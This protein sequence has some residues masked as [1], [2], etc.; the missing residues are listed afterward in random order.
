MSLRG[1]Q[2]ITTSPLAA[3]GRDRRRGVSGR[4]AGA[5]TLVEL[6]IVIALSGLLLALLFSPLIQGFR[7]TNKARSLTQ[8]QDAT[9]F[10]LEQFSRELSQASYVFD[11]T[12]SPVVLPFDTSDATEPNRPNRDSKYAIYKSDANGNLIYQPL[13][14]FG[15]IDFIPSAIQTAGANTVID[16]TTNEPLGGGDLRVPVA[17]GTRYVRYFVGLR[18]TKDA[19][20]NRV[21]YGNPF[22]FPRTDNDFNPFILYRAVYDPSDPNLIR[23]DAAHT[24]GGSASHLVDGAGFDDPD[25]FYNKA[26]APNGVSYATN[27]Q[28]IAT[29]IVSGTNL[30][31]VQWRRNAN[32]QVDQ[33]T[34]Y[35]LGTSFASGTVVGDTAT[36]GFLTNSAAEEPNAV[37]SLYTTQYGQW[38][39]PFS[40]TVYR[41]STQYSPASGNNAGHNTATYGEVT[42]TF[43]A[44]ANGQVQVVPSNPVGSLSANNFASSY[45][46]MYSPSTGK[47]FVALPNMTFYVD[48]ARGR[49]E[50]GLPPLAG[51]A[52]GA[53][54]FYNA[55]NGNAVNAMVA[56]ASGNLGEVVQTVYRQNTLDT[57][58]AG[59]QNTATGAYV[60]INQGIL[61]ADLAQTDA[62]NTPGGYYELTGTLPSITSPGTEYP[63]PFVAFG[64]ANASATGFQSARIIRGTETVIGPDNQMY[65]IGSGTAAATPPVTYLRLPES[66]V[67]TSG[68]GLA[69]KSN[70][71]GAGATSFYVRSGPLNYRL[72]QDLASYNAPL[73]R[74]DQSLS[75]SDKDRP[76]DPNSS[77][78]A[79]ADLSNPQFQVAGLPARLVGDSGPDRDIQVTFLWQN[80]Y[81]RSANGQPL[82]VAGNGPSVTN[83]S[84]KPE[85]D[86]V[87]VNYSTRS[88]VNIALGVRVYDTSSGQAQTSQIS[89]KIK[90]NNVGR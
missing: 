24:S 52:N 46:W 68:D 35:A 70:V 29:P 51:N 47:Y 41:G 33:T 54:L 57:R 42:L 75:P 48:P 77:A 78:F 66:A 84:V 31:L 67:S 39:L 59:Q 7:L 86:V 26:Q 63:S 36:P 82:D 2:N 61:T 45:F 21:F 73:L 64:G 10:G 15:K 4:L 11:N 22:E 71:A 43:Q 76:R 85:A 28:A 49:I 37:A 90:V 79:I 80:N 1:H 74:F 62:A 16:P 5:F 13:E 19:Q 44:G 72:E 56:G 25:F 12:N 3:Q 20:G 88:L 58:V 65:T 81:A 89:D 30:D 34:P 38:V 8:A 87:K 83:P 55:N 23:Q 18:R 60:P 6:L 14:A 69:K 40:V 9:R 32:R 50:T 17:P 27:W 53:P